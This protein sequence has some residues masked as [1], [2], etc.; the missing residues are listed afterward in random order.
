MEFLFDPGGLAYL[1]TF[2][3]N[4]MRSYAQQRQAVI[5]ECQLE[6]DIQCPRKPFRY[7]NSVNVHR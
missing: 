6:R 5:F 4:P 2:E 7:T 1:S 3:D